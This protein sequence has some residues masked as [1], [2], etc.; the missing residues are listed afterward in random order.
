MDAVDSVTPEA[1]FFIAGGTL[2][3]QSGSYLERAA[4]V[5]IVKALCEGR[6]CYVLN[7]RQMGKSSLCV[8]TMARLGEMGVKTAFIDLTKIGGRN[9]TAE[10]WYAGLAIEAG[11]TL[12]LQD[13]V[14]DYWKQ[15]AHL[16]AMQRFFGALQNVVLANIEGKVVIFVDEIDSTRS[17]SFNSDEFF[18]G[19]RECFNRRVHEPAFERLTFCFLGVAVPSDLIHDARTTPF[20]IG[21]RIYLKDFTREECE[22]LAAHLGSRGD[23]VLDR[24]FYWTSGHPFLTQSICRALSS[25]NTAISDK[26]VDELIERDLLEPK[27]RETN[28]N[29]SDVGNRVLNGYA[30]GDD[31]AK[32]RA[33]ILSAYGRALSGR[34]TL[35]DDESNR[36]TAVLKLSG[37]MRSEGKSLRVRNRIYERAFD[38]AWIKE[39]MPGQELRRQR[40]AFYLGVVRTGLVALV[41]VAII[42]ALA[43]NGLRL[44]RIATEQRDLAR[45]QTYVADVNLMREAYND[46]D[47]TFLARLLDETRNSPSRNIEWFYWN[48]KLNEYEY[49][50]PAPEGLGLVQIASDGKTSAIYDQNRGTVDLCTYPELKLTQSIKGLKRSDNLSWD[51]GRWALFSLKNFQHI[52]VR[53]LLTG[54]P[55]GAVDLGDG[56]GGGASRS[57]NGNALALFWM[58]KGDPYPQDAT[59]FD[60]KT[61]KPI[62]HLKLKGLRIN[63]VT[64]SNDGRLVAMEIVDTNEATLVAD[65]FGQRSIATY[66]MESGRI[67]DKFPADGVSPAIQLSGD[68]RYLAVGSTTDDDLKVRD[69]ANHRFVIQAKGHVISNAGINFS[70]DGTK[71]LC[72]GLDQAAYLWDVP[73]GRMVQSWKGAI[74]AALAPDGRTVAIAGAGTR[75]YKVG[76]KDTEST[77]LPHTW[78]FCRGVCDVGWLTVITGNS[79]RFLDTKTL[80]ES[81][82]VIR[83]THAGQ[84]LSVDCNW[85]LDDLPKGGSEVVN[86]CTDQVLCHV[87]A[88]N[89]LA[90]GFDVSQKRTAMRNHSGRAVFCFDPSGKQVWKFDSTASPAV[91]VCWS[92]DGR[93]LAVGTFSGLAYILDGDTGKVRVTLRDIPS[94][95]TDLGFTH[96]SK[97]LAVA[98]NDV[99]VPIF[100]TETGRLLLTCRGHSN[101]VEKVVFTKDDTRLGTASDDGTVRFWDPLTGKQVMRLDISKTLATG[102]AFDPDGVRFY[103]SDYTGTIRVFHAP[104]N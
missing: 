98:S 47:L 35:V 13:K 44:A 46:N 60:G 58:T 104:R 82:P 45:Y 67:V 62:R 29:L 23:A 28:I 97:R 87:P 32:F 55:I 4:D 53:D 26:D 42:T 69:V 6:F 19:V 73:S 18:A 76:A 48:S 34:E 38:K 1:N 72:L 64:S 70:S 27:V 39:N 90:L 65:Y 81:H 99:N 52:P 43:L 54:K 20:N 86:V 77:Q 96:D 93:L 78:A 16:G 51:G 7:S 95:V 94:Q 25:L 12:G 8:R 21:D 37:L 41:V 56:I 71:M 49:E 66:D 50:S 89:G 17:L 101:G 80:R 75:V 10:Q 102:I 74:S 3:L 103:T 33:D 100:D 59:T 15:E 40:R 61:L 2:P 57:P 91:A 84:E 85:R 88:S 68:G 5:A 31:V 30:D 36:I 83:T 9:V 11:R 92:P 24:I 14:R 22:P 63:S 79:F